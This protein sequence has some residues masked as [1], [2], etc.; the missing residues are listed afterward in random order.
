MLSA[1]VVPRRRMWDRDRG[2]EERVNE[3]GS[4]I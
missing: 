3:V 2:W 1:D 4:E